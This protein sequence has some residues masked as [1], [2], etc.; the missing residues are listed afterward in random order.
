MILMSVKDFVLERGNKNV[1]ELNVDDYYSI[2]QNYA[3]FLN[4]PLT[5]GMFVPTDLN[6]NFLKTPDYNKFGIDYQGKIQFISACQDYRE[7]E[8]RVLFKTSK[9]HY[10]L[11]FWE[12]LVNQFSNIESLTL[13]LDD[14]W[15]GT[16]ELTESAKKQIGV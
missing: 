3:N 9:S 14:S 10:S 15:I 1:L 13:D 5:L 2:T 16:L 7:A 8:K 11:D 4:Q 6:G 12:E